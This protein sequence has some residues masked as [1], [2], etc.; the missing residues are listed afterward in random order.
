MIW[1]TLSCL[2]MAI[3]VGGLAYIIEQ[4]NKEAEENV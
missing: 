2:M 3:T 4:N 1:I